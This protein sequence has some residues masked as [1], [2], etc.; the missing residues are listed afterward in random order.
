MDTKGRRWGRVCRMNWEIGTDIYK[1]LI[2]FIKHITN[3]NVLYST[4]NSTQCSVM[5]YMGRKSEKKGIC[6]Y[7]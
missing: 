3:E 1:L 6:V 5:T 2:L 4:G 7:M